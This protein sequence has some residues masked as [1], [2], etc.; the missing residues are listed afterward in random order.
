MEYPTV[1][2]FPYSKDIGWVHVHMWYKGKKIF[3]EM[4]LDVFFWSYQT[5]IPLARDHA[6]K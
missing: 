3:S 2:S 1:I 5:L 6:K 4:P